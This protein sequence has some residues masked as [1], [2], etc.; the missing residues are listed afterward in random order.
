MTRV[1]NRGLRLLSW[2]PL[3]TKNP[4][5]GLAKKA[6]AQKSPTNS[7]VEPI[8]ECKSHGVIFRILKLFI[9]VKIKNG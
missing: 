4:D 3:R 2:T 1:K 6:R 9:S 5:F 7:R 8:S